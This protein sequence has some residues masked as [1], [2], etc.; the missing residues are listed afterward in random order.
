MRIVKV[1]A[2]NSQSK[3]KETFLFDD[4][5][6]EKRLVACK[7]L[8][9]Y[10]EFCFTQKIS[11]P[12]FVEIVFVVADTE[13]AFSKLHGIDG[14][15]RMTLKK[16]ENGGFV[17]LARDKDAEMYMQNNLHLSL[18]DMLR[19]I[20]VT[21][22]TVESFNGDLS[23]F[24][25]LKL[26]SD[27][28]KEILQSAAAVRSQAETAKEK[29]KK[30]AQN[31][32]E[33]VTLEQISQTEREAKEVAR[34]L[35]DEMEKMSQLKASR[36]NGG[37]RTE[38]SQKLQ[39]AQHKYNQLLARQQ[40]ADDARKKVS[41]RDSLAVL[42]PKIRT[43]QSVAVE[44]SEYETKRYEITS[45][46]DWKEKELDNVV[47][48]YDE[49]QL[50]FK[51]L[52]DKRARIE[53][54]NNEL[55]YISSLYEQNQKLN[56]LLTELD[57]K[58]RRFTEERKTCLEK[59]A[60]LEKSMSEVKNTL[61]MY[62]I[63]TKS[64]GELMETVRV[65]V[66]IEE[67]TAQLEKLQNEIAIKESQIA[68]KESGLVLQRKRF[69]S[70]AELDA[71]VTPIKAKDTIL[72]VL[73][74]K[75]SKLEAINLSLAEKQRNL[76]RALEDYNYRISQINESRSKLVSERNK[77]LLRKQE[78]FK[79]EVFLNSQKVFNDDSSSVF[80]VTANFQDVE[81]GTLD[82]EIE[83]RNAERDLLVQR[84]AQLEGAI[85]EIKRHIEINSAE[86][87]TLRGE[88][89]NI[90]KRYSEIVSQNSS[91][92][93][94]N[95][96][97]AL[98]NDS[99]T[100][101]LLDVQQD[102]VRTDAELVEMKRSVEAMRQKVSS[103]KARL[104]YLHET[105][106]HLDDA[107]SNVDSFVNT[108]DRMKESLTDIG[109]RLSLG[110]E[111]Y[112]SLS[113]QLETLNT[114]LDNI[115]AAVTETTKTVKVNEAQIR[116]ST[117]KAKRLAGSDN[118]EQTISNFQYDLSDVESEVQ[119]LAE[120][121]QVLSKD[122][123][124]K[125]L[126]LSKVQWLY[127]TK[128]GEYDELYDEIQPE[129]VA[130]GWDMDRAL[131]ADYSEDVESLRKNIAKF[132][133]LKSRLAER[134][135]NYYALLKEF[136]DSVPDE[137]IVAQQQKVEELVARQNSLEML[138]QSQLE[139]YV[140]AGN[141]KMK[142]TVAAAEARTL[143]SLKQTLVHLEIVS[144]LIADKISTVLAQATAKLTTLLGKRCKLV[145]KDGFVQVVQEENVYDYDSLP[146]SEKAAVYT[147]LALTATDSSCD[148]W[149]VFDDGIG[150]DN[151]KLSAL[152]R[153]TTNV[154]FAV[155]HSVE[156]A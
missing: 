12:M 150:L 22:N 40:E 129:L 89:E 26:L 148:K 153:K 42:V 6:A 46:L 32:F 78:E 83:S 109:E 140:A 117:A 72:Q 31:E 75:Y 25:Q 60:S 156:N 137:E 65:D 68:E 144:L 92:A 49:K 135:N 100:K 119:M 79:R 47:K 132:D 93:V 54:V 18:A 141:A 116:Q 81:I 77:A 8:C 108:N 63:P 50:Q 88:K 2:V 10:L 145:E 149:I 36:T 57:A 43:L 105:Q 28:K 15:I 154:Y 16:K 14:A 91:E 20:C 41:E 80:A 139:Q 3:Q 112:V 120:S 151:S 4:A 70:V 96:L 152:L 101:Y 67:V 142:V 125:R 44:R 110:Y 146:L 58:K 121:K 133:S 33:N 126:E 71:A 34:L 19:L 1:L 131:A 76:E 7:N 37:L 130:L 127:E 59:L 52:Q 97:K 94:F 113:K 35:N 74:A 23:Q 56:E 84:A 86:M 5:K 111:Q 136:G 123:F 102:A 134:I 21:Q 69:N 103:L 9:A 53:E 118:L 90:N 155:H 73:E 128:C 104:S 143:T 17:T 62:Q 29:V 66:K 55:S 99:S 85:K 51:A 45:E 124:E 106:S 114:K 138:R 27:I 122:V 82:Q 11:K 95:Y 61:D 147:A 39:D 30:Y 87:E 48:Q 38:I 107:M 115:G 64:V 24:S 13:Y 98:H